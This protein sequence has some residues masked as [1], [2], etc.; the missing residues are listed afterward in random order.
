MNPNSRLIFLVLALAIAGTVSFLMFKT[1]MKKPEAV[2]ESNKIETGLVAVAARDVDRGA[3]L[4]REDILLVPFLQTSIPQGSLCDTEK[5]V[6]RT[7]VQPVRKTELLLES[8]LAPTDAKSGGMAVIVT[9]GK[10]AMAVKVDKV[11]GVSNFLKPGHFVDVLVSI[12]K[13]DDTKTQGDVDEFMTKM[14]LENI[15]VLSS[16]PQLAEGDK[17]EAKDY[18]VVTLEVDPEEAE[19]LGLALNRGKIQLALRNYSDKED[20]LTRGATVTN[21]LASYQVPRDAVVVKKVEED[22]VVKRVVPVGRPRKITV[23]VMNGNNV[24]LIQMKRR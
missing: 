20:E 23:E 11:I 6:G 17:K 19:K 7:L 13:E 24:Q 12:Q 15:L 3:V 8:T 14:V 9:P 16:G 1:V 22:K 4:V 18:D 2:P 21:L 5:L 10:R